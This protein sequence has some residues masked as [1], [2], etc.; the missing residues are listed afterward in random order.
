MVLISFYWQ[1]R[2]V[3]YLNLRQILGKKI[4]LYP[5]TKSFLNLEKLHCRNS[6]KVNN[7]ML[8]LKFSAPK[9]KNL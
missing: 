4:C 8:Y 6:V 5:Y 7:L 1:I 2:S 3:L 9:I